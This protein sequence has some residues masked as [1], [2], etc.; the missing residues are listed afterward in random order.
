MAALSH[1]RLLQ[2]DLLARIETR[3]AETPTAVELQVE[4]AHL[5][6]ELGRPEEGAQA[7]RRAVELRAPKYPITTRAYSVLPHRGQTLPITVLL[8]VSP[9]WGNAPFRRYLDEQTF[10]TL[11]IITDY[12]DPGLSLPPHQLVVNCISDADSCAASLEA[13]QALMGDAKIPVIN[14]PSQVE[15]T[16]RE[17]NAARLASI[18][19]VR[20]PKIIT[21]SREF[22]TDGNVAETLDR[23]GF[24]F[25][26]L[27]RAPG[28]HTGQHFVRVENAQELSIAL[29]DLPGDAISV[30]EFLDARSADGDFHR[31]ESPLFQRRDE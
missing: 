11:Q 17:S 15:A 19:G 31:L 27:L 25:P 12:H 14:S 26:L 24:S 23:R 28:F 8:L 18:P 3:L 22:L 9:A 30:I 6:A 1:T 20:A 21:V 5:L 4:R 16:G 7:Y 10:L 29:P 2:E 13:A